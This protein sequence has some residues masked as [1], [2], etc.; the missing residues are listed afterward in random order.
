MK[1]GQAIGA[2][3]KDGVDIVDQ[4]V[5][6]MD[7]IA[8]MTKAMGINLADPVHHAPRPT[9]QDRR[10][11]PADQGAV[12]LIGRRRSPHFDTFQ[13]DVRPLRADTICRRFPRPE[14]QST[15]LPMHLAIRRAFSVSCPKS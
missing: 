6:V 13:N 1:S 7:L 11:R 10:R 15:F 2:T 9:D 14:K 8:T 5:G 3:D 12:R 4:P